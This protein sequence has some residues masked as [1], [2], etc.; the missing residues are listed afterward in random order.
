MLKIDLNIIFSFLKSTGN[1]WTLN[2]P[3]KSVTKRDFLT[4]Y[5]I[6]ECVP[7]TIHKEIGPNGTQTMA[8]WISNRAKNLYFHPKRSTRFSIDLGKR[9]SQRDTN[10]RQFNNFR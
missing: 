1:G 9:S 6:C 2:N 4:E 10:F 8:E 3:I 7:K 5:E